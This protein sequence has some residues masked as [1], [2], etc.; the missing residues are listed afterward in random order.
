MNTRRGAILILVVGISVLILGVT[1]SFVSL[2][3]SEARTSTTIIDDIQARAMLDAALCYVA[4][5]SRIGWGTVDLRQTTAASG[6]LWTETMGWNDVRNG[7]PGPFP[8][9]LRHTSGTIEEDPQE[10]AV[11]AMPTALKALHGTEWPAMGSV[12][13][14]DCHVLT[15][16]P[17]AVSAAP[18]N[19]HDATYTGDT[20]RRSVVHTNKHGAWQ[21]SALAETTFAALPNP[22]PAPAVL[23]SSATWKTD[24][25]QGDDT[26]RAT[27]ARR[28]WFRVHR[29]TAAQHDG[30]AGNYSA[31]GLTDWYDTIDLNGDASNGAVFVITA[32][33]GP[34]LGFRDF[35]EAQAVL[36]ASTATALF[37]NATHFTELRLGETILWYRAEW[38]PATG[39]GG[40]P[41]GALT[42]SSSETERRR[43]VNFAFS[44]FASSDSKNWYSVPEWRN[45]A[46]WPSGSGGN[47]PQSGFRRGNQPNVIAPRPM[48]F[49]RFA[50]I[51]HLERE[52]PT[53]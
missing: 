50:W 19:T 30:T 48:P 31:N 12:M 3:R 38:T 21:R 34:T 4:E 2:V 18:G 25:R 32:G 24:W 16:S 33:C 8:L 7:R 43:P 28:A 37:G 44:L 1:V 14:A 20:Q 45:T 53:W 39:G 15:R 40:A 49:G 26:P 52:P 36:G 11:S 41:R 13:R 9:R 42:A 5:T 23:P 10:L 47:N 46:G 51:Q 29:E 35:A 22:D 27:S 17:F 6:V